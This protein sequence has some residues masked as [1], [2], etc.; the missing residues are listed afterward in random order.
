MKVLNGKNESNLEKARLDI[1]LANAG[2]IIYL[3][4]KS[5]T[6]SQGTKIAYNAIKSGKSQEKLN[7]FIEIS[8]MI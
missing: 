8:N 7:E 5:N 6:I 2:A 4:G 1:A 3:A